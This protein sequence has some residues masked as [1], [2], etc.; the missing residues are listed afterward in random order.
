MSM[1]LTMDGSANWEQFDSFYKTVK[2]AYPLEWSVDY[3]GIYPP[4]ILAPMSK[5]ICWTMYGSENQ[6]QPRA[7][8]LKN[9]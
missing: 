6:G 2:R 4:L 1:L 8:P 9:R 7:L 5:N 3:P